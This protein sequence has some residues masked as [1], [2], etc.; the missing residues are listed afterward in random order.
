MSIW[1]KTLGT[2]QE[3]ATPWAKV[4]GTWPAMTSVWS[5][6]NGAWNEVWPTGGIPPD[7]PAGV[8][9]LSPISQSLPLTGPGFSSY[10][11]L[12]YRGRITEIRARVSWKPQ[13]LCL[14]GFIYSVSGRP[15]G[16][17]YR[18]IISDVAWCGR[19]IDHRIDTF[20]ATSLTQFN[21]GT[22]T[23]FNYNTAGLS[24]QNSWSN[25][26]LCLTIV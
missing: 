21:D 7:I 12:A 4:A 19:T 3:V 10:D 2:W 17:F 8:Y 11:T 13:T 5:K 18:D 23:G 16:T 6:V 1:V 22:A 20:N 24:L 25:V 14:P 15:G 9:C 26:Q